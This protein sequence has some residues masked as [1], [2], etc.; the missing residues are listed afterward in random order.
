MAKERSEKSR[1]PSRYSPGGWVTGAQ[2][3]IE[4]LCE[5]Q[6]RKK[7]RD[8][9]VRFWTLPAWQKEFASQTRATNRLIKK[10]SEKAIINAIKER[11]IWSLRPKWV[12]QVIQAEQKKID[13][14]KEYEEK[15]KKRAPKED[16]PVVVPNNNKRRRAPS[17]F[18]KLLAIDDEVDNGEEEERD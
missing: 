13:K 4:L 3:I 18:K 16:K 17:R 6:A 14:K 5:R 10:Y 9:P 11:H 8:L 1:W 12:E 7:N 2:Y 15:I